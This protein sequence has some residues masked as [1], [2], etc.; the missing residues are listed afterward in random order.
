MKEMLKYQDELQ[1][2]PIPELNETLVKYL[3]WVK[4]LLSEEELK[5]TVDVVKEFGKEQGEGERLHRKL[6][7]YKSTIEE[8]KSWLFPMW[9]EMYLSG[10]GSIIPDISF[11]ALLNNDGYRDKYTLEEILGKVAYTTTGIYHQISDGTLPV[12]KIKGNSIC[13]EQYLRLFKSM[14]IANTDVDDFYVGQLAKENNYCIVYNKNN[15]YKVI[16]TDSNGDRINPNSLAKAIEFITSKDEEEEYNP[17]LYTATERNS[18]KNILDKI[19]VCEENIRNFEEVK[20]ALFVICIDDAAKGQKETTQDLLLSDGSN[21]CFDKTIQFIINKNKEIGA[22]IEHTGYDGSTAFSILERV[23]HELESEV[24]SSDCDDRYVLPRKLNFA[25]TDEVKELLNKAKKEQEQ[26]SKDYHLSLEYFNEFGGNKAKELKVSPDAYFHIALQ[27]AQYKT[28]GKIRSTYEPV[29]VRNFRQGRTECA[30]SSSLEKAEF[31]KSFNEKTTSRSELY[32]LLQKAASSHVDRIRECQTGHG[33]ERH[34]FG[35]A[36][37]QAKFGQELDIC[38][39]PKLF[40]DKGYK[41]LKTDFISTSAV[42]GEY[43]RYCA[44]G[45]QTET[46]FGIFYT[47]CKDKIAINLAAKAEQKSKA[48]EFVSNL[49]SAFTEIKDFIEDLETN[50]V[51]A[52]D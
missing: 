7:E 36:Q 2:L 52:I 20:N 49:M 19:L 21:R 4:P 28:F 42:G 26:K 34:L 8:N 5:K 14:R 16:L 51:P 37:M 47:I 45:P 27:V 38:E 46:G 44:F 22:N 50:K 10:R 25:L 48:E 15:I 9:D 31:A 29:A 3:Q 6:L 40:T 18:A 17:F 41:E 30:R 32:D 23:N 1:A 35:L 33:V 13:M 24:L 39:L 11:C 12:D 43:I